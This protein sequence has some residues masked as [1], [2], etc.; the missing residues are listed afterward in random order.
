MYKIDSVYI[1]VPFCKS[2][3]NY[4]AFYSVVSNRYDGYEKL[5]AK[6]VS[7]Y[8][9]DYD[10]SGVKT[11]YFGGG[12]PSLLKCHQ[13]A[14]MLSIFKNELLEEVTV[15]VNPG[16][17]DYKK[18]QC[19]KEIGVNRLSIGF[20]SMDDET[21]LF[22]GR[23]HNTKDNLKAY[24]LA[25]NV[26]FPNIS[27][28][29]IIGIPGYFSGTEK[30]I[31]TVI[32]LNPEH[33]S[34]YILSIEEGTKFYRMKKEQRLMYVSE[35]TVRGEYLMMCRYFKESKYEHYEISN[36]SK[37]GKMSLHNLNYWKGGIYLGFGPSASGYNGDM[38][39]MNVKNLKIYENKISKGER[40][41]EYE[42]RLTDENKINEFVFLHLR[43]H[44][45]LDMD[46]L[47]SK[48]GVDF[49]EKRGDK[50]EMFEERKLLKRRGSIIKLT[51]EGSL[52]SDFIFGELML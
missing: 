5:I 21:L 48:F 3:C 12:T 4:C 15:E 37:S 38:R 52:V 17:V 14:D 20:Q 25:R 10:F 49:I 27:V 36:F 7:L 28:D 23:L 41:L 42:E 19:L 45:G 44:E 2:K 13:I 26:G 22:L 40:P 33:I 16:T 39:Y 24:E 31:R 30:T 47:K 1:H 51:E 32:D 6:E 35:E 29:I 50:L 11:V 9:R 46:E 18:L 8:R 34:S 43:L